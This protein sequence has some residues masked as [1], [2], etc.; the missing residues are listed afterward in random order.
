MASAELDL[1]QFAQESLRSYAKV[2]VVLHEDTQLTGQVQVGLVVGRCGEQDALAVVSADVLPN[3][4]IPPALAVTQVVALV[5]DDQS[6]SAE[7][8]Q[9]AQYPAE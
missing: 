1:S 2:L 4:A 3:R 5:D 9:F 8:W 6:V 7:I